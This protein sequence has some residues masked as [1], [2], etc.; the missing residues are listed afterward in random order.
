MLAF[1]NGFIKGISIWYQTEN[2]ILPPPLKMFFREKKM[3]YRNM[4]IF[5]LHTRLLCLSQLY[6]YINLPFYLPFSLEISLFLFSF[7][8]FLF[9]F[10]FSYFYLY[11]TLENI[12]REVILYLPHKGFFALSSYSLCKLITL[13]HHKSLFWIVFFHTA[14]H[15][16]CYKEFGVLAQIQIRTSYWSMLVYEFS[17]QR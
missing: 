13:S 1:S 17:G 4:Q 2:H 16:W 3:S 14:L 12:P 8:L 5:S 9:S 7:T 11:M 6:V 15:R 10:P